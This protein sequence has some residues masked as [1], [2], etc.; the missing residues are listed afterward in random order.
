MGP[1]NLSNFVSRFKRV[2]SPETVNGLGRVVRF[3][4][5]ERIITPYRLALSLLASCATMRVETLADIQRTFNAMFA[6]TVAYKPFHNQL[7]KCQFGDFM[8]ELVALML[9]HWVV[10][11]L[12]ANAAGGAF[13]EFERIVIQD[14]S[15]FALK[16]TLSKIYPGRFKSKGPAAVELHVSMDLL[17]E[18]L[19]QVVLTPDT[20]TERA[21]LPTPQQ[22]QGSL[23]LADRGY[24][25]IKYLR[26]LD[27]A[28]A[29]FV[30]R[31]FTSINP[32]ILAAYGS[33]GEPLR[34]RYGKALK[35]IRLPKR[36][37]LDLD[38]EWGSG[39]SAFRCRVVVSWNA[40]KKEY[41]Y[42]VTNLPRARYSVEQI[43]QAY[44]LRWQVELLFKEWK[45]Y[46]NLHAFDTSNPSIAE[47]LIWAAIGAALLKRLLAHTT[48]LL[49]GVEISTRKVAMCA[50]HVL[51]DIFA[52]LAAERPR[53]LQRA[54]QVALDYLA[55]NAQRAH[56][57]RDRRTGRLQLGFEPVIGCA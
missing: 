33:D 26:E 5:R 16:E 51:V 50:H 29:H 9:E 30:V 55:A 34:G 23:L 53:R 54:F 14:G 32:T 24:F 46:A 45:S 7:A 19:T 38:V 37:M 47:G 20:F 4:R 39:E 56:P 6:T 10:R 36:K 44:R 35:D 15:S 40:T 27:K 21:E 1:E 8:R 42:L 11:V 57:T 3:C 2:L 25:D 31:G 48:Q 28:G 18:S 52:V 13:G 43:T 41:R 12:R 17:E 49:K 22:L